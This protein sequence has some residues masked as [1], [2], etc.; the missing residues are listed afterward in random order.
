MQNINSHT[1]YPDS[2]C[3]TTTT[4][5][6]ASLHDITIHTLSSV[7]LGG[8][9]IQFADLHLSFVVSHDFPHRPSDDFIAR[10]GLY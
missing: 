3:V 1:P 6:F 4:L 9:E 8:T 7:F 2:C 5:L 10:P